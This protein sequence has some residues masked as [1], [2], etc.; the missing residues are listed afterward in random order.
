MARQLV[1]I[2]TFDQPPKA[3]LAQNALRAAGIQ[4]A[5][6]DEGVVA[7]DWLLSNA[8]GGIKVQVW[9]DDAE[10]AVAE[11]ERAFGAAGEG[12][13]P[14]DPE[15]FAAE[16]EAATPEEADEPPEEAFASPTMSAAPMAADDDPA[17]ALTEREEYARRAFYAALFGIVMPVLLFYSTYLV[18]VAAFTDGRLNARARRWT[19]AAFGLTA[20]GLVTW[21]F[22]VLLRPTD[23]LF[24]L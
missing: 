20:F 11:L 2:A 8:V 14:I 5:V 13:G 23:F 3:R 24:V 21:W 7:M 9:E 17:D 4:A 12:L 1:T 10:R 15:A 22:W 6:T 18:M 16:A 19:V